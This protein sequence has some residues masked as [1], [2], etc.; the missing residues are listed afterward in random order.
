MIQENY[1]QERRNDLPQFSGYSVISPVPAGDLSEFNACKKVF[2][3]N[4]WNT[5]E[6]LV[7]NID[8]INKEVFEAK[9]TP[10]VYNNPDALRHLFNEIV[11]PNNEHREIVDV[12]G[13]CKDYD[14]EDALSDEVSYSFTRKIIEKLEKTSLPVGISYCSK[15]LKMPRS[16]NGI[17]TKT[18]DKLEFKEDCGNHASLVIGSRLVQGK[19][20][21]KSCELL[22]RNTWGS[23]CQKYHKDHKCEDGNI[24]VDFKTLDKNTYRIQHL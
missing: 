20:G 11:C 19:D 14:V 8:D 13:S 18:K 1:L 16:Y 23:D 12:K 2:F 22:I 7:A 10:A 21:K 6:E 15:M 17:K 5:I 24:W 4:V 3:P 9:F